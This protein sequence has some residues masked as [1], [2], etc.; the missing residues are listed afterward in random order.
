VKRCISTCSNF[1]ACVDCRL[2]SLQNKE[3]NGIS[4]GFFYYKTSVYAM[5]MQAVVDSRKWFTDLCIGLPSSI[6]NSCF[7]K[8]SYLYWSIAQ[9]GLMNVQKCI[10]DNVPPYLTRNKGYPCLLWL[11]VRHKNE[12]RQPLNVLEH[13]FN[14]RPS[15]GRALVENAFAN[16]KL[17][18]KELS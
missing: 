13:L 16:L 5:H 2:C 15:K 4:G 10:V 1:G 6:N 17:M 18:F 12:G 11:L 3:A 8:K 14:W 7:F 9:W